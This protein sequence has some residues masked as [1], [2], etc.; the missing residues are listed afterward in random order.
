M[1]VNGLRTVRLRLDTG[2]VDWTEVADFDRERVITTVRVDADWLD[3]RTTSFDVEVALVD[4][5]PQPA[6]GVITG[7]EY[8]VE[9]VW[10]V[11]DA[12]P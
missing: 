6:C 9:P 3:G 5:V 7:P 12:E 1:R 2:A 11:L 8:G 4:H 10:A